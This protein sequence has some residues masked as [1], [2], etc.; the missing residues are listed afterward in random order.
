MIF[1]SFRRPRLLKG[2]QRTPPNA[3]SRDRVK[4]ASVKRGV[5]VSPRFTHMVSTPLATFTHSLYH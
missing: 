4:T 1:W 2:R 3:L 5:Q